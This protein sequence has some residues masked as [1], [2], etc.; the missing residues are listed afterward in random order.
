MN[1]R[2]Q[3]KVV[4]RR[5]LHRSGLDLVRFIDDDDF[6]KR[7]LRLMQ[8]HGIDVVL[9]VGANAGQYAQTLRAIGYRGR[10]VSFE[11]LPDAY[12]AL[13]VA[14][15][16]DA[17]WQPV[18]VALG[19]REGT[20]VINVSANSQSSSILPMLPAHLRAAPGSGYVDTA[21]VA[22]TTLSAVIDE[23]VSPAEAVFVKLDTQGYERQIL[24]GAE[25]RFDRVSGIQVELSLVPLYE[26]QAMVEE[27]I[28]YLRT[29]GFSPV[30]I[31]PDFWDEAS[32]RLLQADG[33]FFR[34]PT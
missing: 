34:L 1:L 16:A 20:T 11:P 5:A 2:T 23:Y 22:V 30:G 4:L 13:Q 3:S 6:L 7:R 32:G 29:R 10:I 17:A 21:N 8:H 9:D 14:A 19:E 33:V 26:G 31:E 12:R 18:N 15:A 27:T 28:A 25:D 24:A